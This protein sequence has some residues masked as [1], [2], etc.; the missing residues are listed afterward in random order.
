MQYF[1]SMNEDNLRTILRCPY[2]MIGTDSAARSFDGITS[3]GK[4]HPRGFGS[5]PRVL[6]RYVREL[7]VIPLEEAVH[8]MTGLPAE[9][10]RIKKRGIISEG[11]FADITVFDAEKITDKAGFDNPFEKPEGIYYVF[12]NG[13]PALWKGS[14]TG[15]LPGRILK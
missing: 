11:F 7:G 15:A 8:K 13:M 3:S 2:T 6:G 10:F 4:P 14:L 5:F 12:V 1:I 9:I